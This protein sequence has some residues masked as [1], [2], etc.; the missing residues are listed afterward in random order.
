MLQDSRSSRLLLSPKVPCTIT[1]GDGCAA[2]GLH[3]QS[4]APAAE[5][6]GGRLSA[7]AGAAAR[8][9]GPRAPTSDA[10]STTIQLARVPTLFSCC[11][12]RRVSSDPAWASASA[13]A[14]VPELAATRRSRC[15]RRCSRCGTSPCGA[16]C[17]NPC[18]KEPEDGDAETDV[19]LD[20]SKFASWK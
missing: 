5:M 15:R 6:V 12:N 13:S 10:T 8:A 20:S 1:T 2:V 14:R 11:Q 16:P 17:Q 3:V 4:F 7:C 18:E 19:S 9:P